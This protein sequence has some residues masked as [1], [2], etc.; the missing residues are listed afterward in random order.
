MTASSDILELQAWQQFLLLEFI[1][2]LLGL[3]TNIPGGARYF[4]VALAQTPYQLPKFRVPL[5]PRCLFVGLLLPL[6][7]GVGP[8]TDLRYSHPLFLATA[9]AS[10]ISIGFWLYRTSR[11]LESLDTQ[12]K[13]EIEAFLDDPAAIVPVPNPSVRTMPRTLRVWSRLNISLFLLLTIRAVVPVLMF[14]SQHR[15]VA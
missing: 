14:F 15:Q 1:G 7:D 8:N 11:F 13:R 6:I 10:L 12:S 2:F 5:L 4:T 9:I 3:L